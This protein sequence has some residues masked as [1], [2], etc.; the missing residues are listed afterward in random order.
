[1][2]M[3]IC[4]NAFL[5]FFFSFRILDAQSIEPLDAESMDVREQF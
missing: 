5:S 2:S 1:M 3:C 4:G